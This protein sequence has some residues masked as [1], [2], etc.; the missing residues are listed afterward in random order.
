MSPYE[1]RRR[2][3]ALRERARLAHERGNA[4]FVQRDSGHLAVPGHA[5]TQNRGRNDLEAGTSPRVNRGREGCT[6]ASAIASSHTE[7]HVEESQGQNRTREIRPS[8][9]V[10]GP[11]ETWPMANGYD[12]ASV[13]KGAGHGPRPPTGARAPDLSRPLTTISSLFISHL[14]PPNSLFT[15][16]PRRD[17][18][19]EDGHLLAGRC[20]QRHR[21]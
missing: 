1:R 10:G 9:I 20:T 2:G 17:V 21:P 11:G 8:G 19:H 16:R 4:E 5:R 12:A 3:N 6:R 14:N 7:R 15:P 13:P 18:T